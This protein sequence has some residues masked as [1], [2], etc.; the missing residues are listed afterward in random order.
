[1]KTIVILIFA[2]I[3]LANPGVAQE[4]T[5][6]KVATTDDGQKVL[7]KSDGTWA[8]I[9]EAPNKDGDK[10]IDEYAS[11]E[12]IIKAKCKDDWPDD[13]AMRS[14]CEDRQTKAVDKL[15]QPRP[16]DVTSAHYSIIH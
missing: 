8:Y 9:K 14:Y 7:L 12:S 3:L 6:D 4:G 2:A 10:K 15:K 16:A 11:A 13:F 1:M 5:R